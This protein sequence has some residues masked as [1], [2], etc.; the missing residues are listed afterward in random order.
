M[1]FQ[2]P[3]FDVITKGNEKL[4]E[5]SVPRKGGQEQVVRFALLDAAPLEQAVQVLNK[6]RNDGEKATAPRYRMVASIAAQVQGMLTAP[7]G[8]PNEPQARA[9]KISERFQIVLAELGIESSGRGNPVGPYRSTISAWLAAGGEMMPVDGKIPAENAIRVLRKISDVSE[10]ADGK[11]DSFNRLLE[12]V[13]KLPMQQ[14]KSFFDSV[15][16]EWASLRD[17]VIDWENRGGDD[18]E[19]ESE[20]Q[21]E[22]AQDDRAHLSPMERIRL[23]LEDKARQEEEQRQAA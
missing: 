20:D 21:D 8:L 11:V 9:K 7:D 22:V 2:I 10:M 16:F 13:R 3:K 23:A 14:Q 6:S 18:D 5:T 17:S 1:K 12:Q 19:A 15:S 4:W